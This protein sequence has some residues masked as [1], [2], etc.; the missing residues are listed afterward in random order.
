MGIFECKIER[1]QIFSK[2]KSIAFLIR[3][4]LYWIFLIIRFYIV[5][6]FNV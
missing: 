3:A 6:I 1:L 2:K 5:S 4:V